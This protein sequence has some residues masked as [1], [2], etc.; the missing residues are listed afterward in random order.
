MQFWVFLPPLL[1]FFVLCQVFTVSVLFCAY[2]CIKCSFDII[3]FLEEI[4]SLSHSIVFIYFSSLFI[5]ESFLI[6]P[7]CSLKHCL[8]LGIYFPVSLA[9]SLLFFPQLFVNPPQI[10]TLLSC[11]LFPWD[12]FGLCP[13][14]NVINLCPFFRHSVYQI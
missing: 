7:C 8:H 1:N 2:L 14:Y 5:E 12:G 4:S 3:N 10:T 9:F 11:F 6:S 13:L